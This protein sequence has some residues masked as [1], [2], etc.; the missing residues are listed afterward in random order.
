MGIVSHPVQVRNPNAS[1]VTTTDG[2]FLRSDLPIAGFAIIEANT[3]EEAVEKV[4]KSPCQFHPHGLQRHRE[5]VEEAVS[6]RR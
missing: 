1:G 3:M 2:P 4:S 6:P 5:L